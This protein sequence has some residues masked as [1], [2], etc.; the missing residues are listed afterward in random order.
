MMKNLILFLM[1]VLVPSITKAQ[2]NIPT[3]HTVGYA[4]EMI[5]WQEIKD[6]EDKEAEKGGVGFFYN[7][8]AQE[9]SSISA[10]CTMRS[11]NGRSYSASNLTDENPMTCWIP[12]KK[13]YGIGASFTI[14]SVNVSG[15]Y[16]GYQA[17]S[18]QWKNNSRVK[19]FK[20]YKDGK[21]VCF[22][23]LADKMDGQY[24][25]LPIKVDYPYTKLSIFKFEIVEVYPGSK[26][27]ET[28]ISEVT[29]SGCC[30][31][32]NTRIRTENSTVE[33]KDLQ[34]EQ[35]IICPNVETSEM[36][37]SEVQKISRQFHVKMLKISTDHHSITVTPDHPLFI[38]GKGFVSFAKL[39]K[40]LNLENY[41]DFTKD[42]ELLT[43][44]ETEKELKFEQLKLIE[45]E[46]HQAE[47]FSIRQ[48][49]DNQTFIANGFVTKTY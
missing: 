37:T 36:K 18:D 43:W 32:G 2:K 26:Y 20:I 25:E 41:S 11:E 38:K 9:I 47:T 4:D 35:K 48:L 34:T 30:F 6:K 16:N 19:K 44:D 40:Q 39:K 5:N 29:Y 14:R 23:I 28:A 21:P 31:A 46:D 7:D 15:I 1:I 27:K 22:L 24:F 17:T 3:I 42:I 49:S 45:V 13:S 12:S 10:S 8:C 33:I